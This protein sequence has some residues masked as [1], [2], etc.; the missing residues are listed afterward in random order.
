MGVGGLVSCK[1][2]FGGMRS[3][4]WSGWSGWSGWRPWLVWSAGSAGSA[5]SDT[6]VLHVHVV[7]RCVHFAAGFSYFLFLR[8]LY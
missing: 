3:F 6:A 1:E 5:G 4:G 8:L 7:A 2:D